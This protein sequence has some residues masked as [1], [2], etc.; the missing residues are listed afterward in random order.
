MAAIVKRRT[1]ATSVKLCSDGYKPATVRDVDIRAAPSYCV[2]HYKQ[3]YYSCSELMDAYFADKTMCLHHSSEYELRYKKYEIIYEMLY[4][5]HNDYNMHTIA[6]SSSG[7]TVAEY[8]EFIDGL[9]DSFRLMGNT[10]YFSKIS[11]KC[12]ETGITSA[13]HYKTSA[14]SGQRLLLTKIT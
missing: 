8:N 13:V 5:T 1:A 4:E 10:G 7:T 3:H 12:T 9:H 14:I 6:L 11:C 2:T